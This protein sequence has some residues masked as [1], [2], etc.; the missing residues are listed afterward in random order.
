MEP[1]KESIFYPNVLAG[2]CSGSRS[3][4]LDKFREYHSYTVESLVEDQSRIII[5]FPDFD[6][7]QHSLKR[8]IIIALV[9]Q[10]P[11]TYFINIPQ[12][13]TNRTSPQLLSNSR[14]TTRVYQ[15]TSQTFHIIH[16]DTARNWSSRFTNIH[17]NDQSLNI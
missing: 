12:D 6:G 14:N 16:L 13:K 9:Y 10:Q 4:I 7:T 3:R 17:T 11:M 8:F 2:I 15:N 1:I 5:I